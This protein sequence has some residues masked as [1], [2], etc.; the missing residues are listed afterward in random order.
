[1]IRPAVAADRD[2]VAALE[3]DCLGPDAWSASVVEAEIAHPDR[4]VLVDERDGAVVAWADLGVTADVADLHR[5]AV[6]PRHRRTGLATALLD[7]GREAV[8]ARGAERLLLEVAA[9]NDAALALYAAR[10]FAPIARRRGYYAGGRDAVVMEL[11]IGSA[12]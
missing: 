5:V 10:G 11:R 8:A 6:A 12:A 4:V 9:D 2:P 7:A 3:R 1:V